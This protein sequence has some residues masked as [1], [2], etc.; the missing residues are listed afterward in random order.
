[1]KGEIGDSTPFNDSVTVRHVSEMLDDYGYQKQGNEIV[2]RLGFWKK[3]F[4]K[5]IFKKIKKSQN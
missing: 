4:K 1:M 2:Y 3:K 5:K